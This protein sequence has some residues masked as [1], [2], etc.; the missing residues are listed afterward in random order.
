MSQ[1]ANNSRGVRWHASLAIV[2]LFCIT[3][4]AGCADQRYKKARMERDARMTKL[5]GG[6][7]KYNTSGFDRMSY[8]A[9][10]SRKQRERQQK[11]LDATLKH[12]EET[13]KRD[14][15][16]WNDQ[17]KNRQSW[18]NRIFKGKPEEIDDVYAKM[19]Y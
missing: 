15:K 7:A 17:Q 2:S 5:A 14:Q 4:F 16:R 18:W 8:V 3:L 1:V 9:G 13:N 19:T 11:S 12:I 10:V 6:Y